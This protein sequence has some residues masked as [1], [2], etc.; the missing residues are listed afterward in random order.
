MLETS[1]TG[2][3]DRFRRGPVRTHLRMTR[4]ILSVP[5]TVSTWPASPYI[6]HR[7]GPRGFLRV[8]S[9]ATLAFADYRGN[10]QLISTGNFAGSDRVSLFLMDYPHRT[11]LKILGHARVVDAREESEL[12]DSLADSSVRK[13]V[14]RLFLID[15][16]SFDWNCP[17]H[18]TPRFTLEEINAY[19]APLRERVSQLESELELL[20]KHLDAPADK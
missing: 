12:A 4:S 15:V 3:R 17:Q 5:A 6:Q 11:R 16:L 7:G 8:T 18:I 1:I 19:V 10:R 14:E 9:P 20:R 13:F 2:N